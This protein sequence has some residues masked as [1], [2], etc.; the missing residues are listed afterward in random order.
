MTSALLAAVDDLLRAAGAGDLA[1]EYAALSDR[2][3]DGLAT[4][5]RLTHVAV[6]AYAAARLPATLAATT[7]VLADL[8][9]GLPDWMPAT[10]LDLGAGIGSAGWA[11]AATFSSIDRVTFVERNDEMRAVGVSLAST[12]S[13]AAI[14]GGAWLSADA[15]GRHDP[16]DLVLAA[17]V[18]GE[19]PASDLVATVGRW[20]DA[21]TDC[22]VL[23]EPGT[24]DGYRRL[25]D[26]RRE[27]ISE[28]A[29]IAAPC[30]HNDPCPLTGGDWCHFMV[31]V[32]RSAAHRAAK[33]ATLT[34]ED[35]KY[36]YVVATRRS[37]ITDPRVL[38]HPVRRAGH[39]RLTV[40]DFDGAS[41]VVVSKKEGARYRAARHAQWGDRFP[42]INRDKRVELSP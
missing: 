22:L 31:R 5:R 12:A 6:L 1:T 39:V 34:H 37:T 35:E 19:L 17:Y 20:W 4:P 8:R 29:T 36:A 41:E 40:C 26:A 15:T 27:L 33:S 21:T 9:V 14:A 38:R 18:L 30:P 7:R 10:A 23:I 32:E 2:Y 3:R 16:S 25:M 42:A 11:A 13:L 24:P 28:G